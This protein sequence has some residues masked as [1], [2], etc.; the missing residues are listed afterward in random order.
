VASWLSRVLDRI[1]TRAREGNVHLTVK[2]LTEARDL[3]LGV[4]DVI[5]ALLA[6]SPTDSAGRRR[7]TLSSEWLYVFKPVVAET[8]LYVKVVLRNDCVVVSF[9]KDEGNEED[10]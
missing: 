5:D 9:H 2:A 10:N 3:D 6:L 8:V 1:H 4:S 7:S